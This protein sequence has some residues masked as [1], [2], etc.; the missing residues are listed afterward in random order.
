[1]HRYKPNI[2]YLLT[3]LHEKS[4][5]EKLDSL[6]DMNGHIFGT[7]FLNQLATDD[8]LNSTTTPDLVCRA[9]AAMREP[10]L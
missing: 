3:Y 4:F 10:Y 2:T 7:F 5:W 1:M 8:I 6:S 9:Q